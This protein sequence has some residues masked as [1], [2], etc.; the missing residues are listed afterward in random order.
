MVYQVE[1]SSNL[2]ATERQSYSCARMRTKQGRCNEA[3][4]YCMGAFMRG[5]INENSGYNP[6]RKWAS[7]GMNLQVL[8]QPY[9]GRWPL[10]YSEERSE[11]V[12]STCKEHQKLS[13]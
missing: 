5:D 4:N 2:I 12:P 10:Y 1:I 13:T 7:E 6:D 11:S 3:N 8:I 9:S